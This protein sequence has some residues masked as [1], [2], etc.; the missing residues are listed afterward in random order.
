[1]QG[2]RTQGNGRPQAG[3]PRPPQDG[4]PHDAA[5]GPRKRNRRRGNRARGAPQQPAM[6][7][8]PR[9]EPARVDDES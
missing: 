2:P 7:G 1:M 5:G 4:R 3:G 9:D 6:E 8:L